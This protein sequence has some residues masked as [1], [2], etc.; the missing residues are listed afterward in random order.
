MDGQN[1]KD[2][3][4]D[5]LRKAIGVVPQDTS[6]FNNTIYYNV[7]Y[8]RIGA[9]QDEVHQAAKRAQI[10]DVIMSL[11]DKYDTKVGERGLM[12]SGKFL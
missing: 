6:L 5:S 3:K 1:I 11:P 12:L 7:A 2:V 8:G 10:H 4:L 9:S